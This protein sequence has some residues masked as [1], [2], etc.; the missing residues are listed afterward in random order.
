MAKKVQTP[1]FVLFFCLFAHNRKVVLFYRYYSYIARCAALEDRITQKEL[2]K[3]AK[4][5]CFDDS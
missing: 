3:L 1:K 2:S 4:F 5:V